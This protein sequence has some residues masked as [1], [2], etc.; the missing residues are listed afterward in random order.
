L[1]S[2]YTLDDTERRR[3]L[4]AL[5]AWAGILQ[6]VRQTRRM[7]RQEELRRLA[8][9]TNVT[10]GSHTVAHQDLLGTRREVVVRELL[11]SRMALE[12][13]LETPVRLMAYPYGNADR[14]I[15]DLTAAAGYTYGFTV[16][17]RGVRAA[18]CPYLLPRLAVGRWMD[19]EFDRQVALA[20]ESARS[21]SVGA[22]APQLIGKQ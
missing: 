11:D 19:A 17:G 15:A 8:A 21:I 7:L 20:L 3:L 22:Q 6:P 10:I 16:D 5:S 14:A 12:S 4:N 9:G 13:V 2:C 18:D 1:R